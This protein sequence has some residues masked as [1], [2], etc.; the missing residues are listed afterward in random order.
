VEEEAHGPCVAP[1]TADAGGSEALRGQAEG[2][3]GG[4]AEEGAGEGG[5]ERWRG[6]AHRATGLWRDCR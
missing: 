2:I 3:A 6:V 5:G 1:A 4:G